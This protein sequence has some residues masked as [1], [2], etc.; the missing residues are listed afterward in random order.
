MLYGLFPQ[1]DLGVDFDGIRMRT[2]KTK[3]LELKFNQSNAVC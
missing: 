3:R 2:E 1:Y